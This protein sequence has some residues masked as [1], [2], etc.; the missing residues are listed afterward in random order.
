MTKRDAPPFG[1]RTVPPKPSNE[2]D[3]AGSDA[4][5]PGKELPDRPARDR[6]VRDTQE[7]PAKNPNE[8][9]DVPS[10]DE[11]DAGA[12]PDRRKPPAR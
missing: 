3:R 9:S 11:K 12:A 7:T 4:D 2:R 1:K 5:E 8:K 10:G 6:P